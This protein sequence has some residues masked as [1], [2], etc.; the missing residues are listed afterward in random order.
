MEFFKK[1]LCNESIMRTK[2]ELISNPAYP[3]SFHH[4]ANK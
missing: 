4:V 1:E 2:E 3:A